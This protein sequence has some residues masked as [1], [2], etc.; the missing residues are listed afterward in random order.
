MEVMMFSA[1][2]S[3]SAAAKTKEVYDFVLDP[4]H[5]HELMGSGSVDIEDIQA[6]PGQGYSYRC[7]YNWDK[8]PIWAQAATT[9]LIPGQ[10][11]VIESVGGIDLIST[12]RFTPEG[13]GTQI[14]LTIEVPQSGLLMPHL[15]AKTI[16]YHI[17]EIVDCWLLNI[18]D[19]AA[20]WALESASPLAT[21]A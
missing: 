14:D 8:F 17:R 19:T 12:W 4:T 3:L 21:A 9:I 7:V 20:Q 10:K 6:L 18:Q 5:V 1:Q 11:I 13:D 15:S 16:N 2:G